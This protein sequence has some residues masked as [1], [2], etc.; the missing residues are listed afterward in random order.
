MSSDIWKMQLG[1]LSTH[2]LI[3]MDLPG[4]GRSEISAA[5]FS[6]TECS[7]SLIE[8]LGSLGID[9]AVVLGWS[10]GAFIAVEMSSRFKANVAALALVSPTPRFVNDVDFHHG[11][12]PEEARGMAAKV[13][14]N[15]KRALAGFQSLMIAPGE[16]VVSGYEEL[17][18]SLAMPTTEVALQSLQALVDADMR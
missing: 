6:I 15:I 1:E 12:S 17:I 13:Q 9:T 14:R 11:L 18:E 8:L 2:R 16:T 3:S 7:Q 10:L 5:G 4:H